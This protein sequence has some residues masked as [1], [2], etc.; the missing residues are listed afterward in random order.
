ML[1]NT[2]RFGTIDVDETRIIEFREGLLG[3]PHYKRFS[4]IQTSTDPVF[5]WLQSVEAADLAFVVCDPLAFVPDY[6]VPIRSE[7]AANLEIADETD[8][9]V[10]VIV[11]KV[12]DHLTGNLLGPL[13]I[14]ATSKKGRQLVLT[15]KRYGTRF[16]LMPAPQKQ[17]LAAARSA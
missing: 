11:N 3:F 10:L 13:V 4:L 8:H 17:T 1:I 12:D 16:P 9:Q 7:D 2:S 5:F 15:D 6:A 14:G